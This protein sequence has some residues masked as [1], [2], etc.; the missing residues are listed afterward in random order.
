MRK[1][2]SGARKLEDWS[3]RGGRESISRTQENLYNFGS[4]IVLYFTFV[5]E[6]N[7]LFVHLVSKN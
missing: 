6:I 7:R 3:L 1:C 5:I 2:G 4:W